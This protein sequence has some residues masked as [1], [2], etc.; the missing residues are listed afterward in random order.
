M[1][2]RANVAPLTHFEQDGTMREELERRLRANEQ[3]RRAEK[4]LV[5][6]ECLSP[7]SRSRPGVRLEDHRDTF[8]SVPKSDSL[9][10][11]AYER[12]RQIPPGAEWHN[13][14]SLGRRAGRT[15]R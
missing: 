5:S 11:A 15:R 2:H 3:R 9:V 10:E 12:V 6:G 8:L 4:G 7:A 13:L 1:S 14:S